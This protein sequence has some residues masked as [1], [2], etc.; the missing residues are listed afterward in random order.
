MTVK[1]IINR[2]LRYLAANLFLESR[3]YPAD[4]QNAAVFSGVTKTLKPRCFFLFRQVSV[5]TPA[6]ARQFERRLAI[7]QKGAVQVPYRAHVKAHHVR[8]LLRRKAMLGAEID[9]LGA[10]QFADIP[11]FAHQGAHPFGG[12]F[13]KR[14]TITRHHNLPLENRGRSVSYIH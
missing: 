10:L 14:T 13:R 6:L 2:R 8:D 7:P 4:F 11:C 9:A 12:A 3:L 5:V 1:Q